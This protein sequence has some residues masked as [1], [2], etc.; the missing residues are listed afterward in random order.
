MR[1]GQGEPFP[2]GL[3]QHGQ[4]DLGRNGL[5][6]RIGRLQGQLKP[7]A[8]PNRP[9]RAAGPF[10]RQVDIK[11]AL[12]GQRRAGLVETPVCPR[13]ALLV[14][15][16]GHDRNGQLEVGRQLGS[17]RNRQRVLPGPQL[18]EPVAENPRRLERDQSQRGPPAPVDD[19]IGR[20]AHLAGEAV[21]ENPQTRRVFVRRN[22]DFGLPGDAMIE[23]VRPL[24]A[25]H[26]A[27]AGLQREARA[28]D[29]AGL[30]SR[31]VDR[32]DQALALDAGNRGP[33][34]NLQCQLDAHRLPFGR[35]RLRPDLEQFTGK[36]HRSRGRKPDGV[37]LRGELDVY[38][39]LEIP[40][41]Q[42]GLQR[43]PLGLVELA[44]RE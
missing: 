10:P 11:I 35:E 17:H 24:G 20:L 13:I 44:R 32:P 36:E 15:L 14:G 41:R 31:H 37:S 19:H 29:A 21:G 26:V 7:L 9:F 25:E 28:P 33:L 43:D 39:G 38:A 3:L 1:A 4:A 40:L 12:D 42:L 34:E 16:V 22:L 5:A 18:H 30:V 8:R 6:Q 23:L 27:P 2:D